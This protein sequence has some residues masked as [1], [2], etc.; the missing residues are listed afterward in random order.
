MKNLNEGKE[1]F[2]VSGWLVD[3]NVEFV[4]KSIDV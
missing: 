4:F 1:K 2:S 3:L